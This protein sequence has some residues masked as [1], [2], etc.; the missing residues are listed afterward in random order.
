MEGDICCR[1]VDYESKTSWDSLSYVL[2]M[3]H[4]IYQHIDAVQEANRR[5]DV[6]DVKSIPE[7]VL[8]FVDLTKEVFQSEK[9]M[10]LIEKNNSLLNG[11]SK[12]KFSGAPRTTTFD[13]IVESVPPLVT[14]EKKEVKEVTSNFA[15]LFE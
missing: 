5:T 15:N 7:N 2:L 13:S 14:K 1:G 10:E 3:A 8:E 4:N 12:A 11:L 6:K 9:P